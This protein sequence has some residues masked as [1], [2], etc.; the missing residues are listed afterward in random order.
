[1]LANKVGENTTTFEDGLVYV[2]RG[3]DNTSVE[4]DVNYYDTQL[5]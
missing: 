4:D 3:K 5:Q 2:V 1:M